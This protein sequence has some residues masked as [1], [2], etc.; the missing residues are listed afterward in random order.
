MLEALYQDYRYP[1]ADEL[2]S[3]L[4]ERSPLPW[5]AI[6]VIAEFFSQTRR[7]DEADDAISVGNKLNA[8]NDGVLRQFK[9]NT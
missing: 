8:G 9:C 2:A 4:L 7:Y 6:Y 5:Q 3:E 1:E